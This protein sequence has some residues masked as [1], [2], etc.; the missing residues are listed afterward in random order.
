MYA[1]PQGSLRL[2]AA[3]GGACAVLT[4]GGC[5][6]APTMNVLGSFFPAWLACAALGVLA[7]ALARLLLGRAGIASHLPL[8][9]LTY[10]GIAVAA[11]LATWLWWLGP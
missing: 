4:L 6:A 9:P 10:L 11:T 5:T 8:P 1:E 3:L 2:V 7:A